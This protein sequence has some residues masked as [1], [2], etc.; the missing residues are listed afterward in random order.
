LWRRQRHRSCG[1]V[2][3]GTAFSRCSNK[4]SPK[5]GASPHPAAK[6]RRWTFYCRGVKETSFA[7]VRMAEGKNRRAGISLSMANPVW[8]AVVRQ[9]KDVRRAWPGAAAQRFR[10][11]PFALTSQ[12]RSQNGRRCRAG[13]MRRRHHEK[14]APDSVSSRSARHARDSTC[15]GRHLS[16]WQ[17]HGSPRRAESLP[18]RGAVTAFEGVPAWVAR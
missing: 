7:E 8:K 11:R 3:C 1:A 14:P 9:G 4:G 10:K 17:R 16:F 18:E 6:S 12:R 2:S 15:R 5:D 13:R